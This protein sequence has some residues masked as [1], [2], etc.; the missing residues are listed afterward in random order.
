MFSKY[1]SN[2]SQFCTKIAC[3]VGFIGAIKLTTAKNLEQTY[4]DAL[5]LN[6]LIMLK[7]IVGTRMPDAKF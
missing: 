5:V 2:V 4:D 3:F 1:C 7:R 6:F